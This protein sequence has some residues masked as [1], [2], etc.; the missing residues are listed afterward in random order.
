MV[1]GGQSLAAFTV[2]LFFVSPLAIA[3]EMEGLP[4]VTKLPKAFWNAVVKSTEKNCP[5]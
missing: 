2:T 1:Y 4:V 3:F 5:G